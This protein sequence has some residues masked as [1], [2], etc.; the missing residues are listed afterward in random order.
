MR[1]N[2]KGFTLIEVLV[3]MAILSVGLLAVIK[4]IV[5][6]VQSNTYVNRYGSA[7]V[8]AQDKMEELRSYA[9]SDLLDN[10][11]PMDFDYLVSAEAE[12]TSLYDPANK[13]SV[14]FPGMLSGKPAQQEWDKWYRP[15]A[16][17]ATAGV[18]EQ[19]FTEQIMLPTPTGATPFDVTRYW[20]VEPVLDADGVAQYALITV[21]VSW[22]DKNGNDRDVELISCINRR[23]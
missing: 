22:K 3:A 23:Q 9:S 4:M 19:Q 1:P 7:I 2:R 18:Y 16:A 10:Y 5:V 20:T 15:M 13:T 14:V 8:L 11:S 6:Y 12:F 17:A 21:N